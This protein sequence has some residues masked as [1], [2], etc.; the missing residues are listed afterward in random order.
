MEWPIFNLGD[1]CQFQNGF[2]FK[3]KYF[4]ISGTP[5]LRISNIQGGSIDL[6]R[7]AYTNPELYKENL[8]KY[9]VM[10]GD[11]LIAMSGATTGK[12]GINQTGLKFLLNQRVG[13]FIPSHKLDK[14]F[15][16]Y[17][18]S[19]KVE[20]LLGISAGAAQ[21]NLSTE[22]IKEMKVPLPSIPEQK[23]IVSVLDTVFSDLEQARAKTEQNLKNARELFDSY[24]QQVFSQKGEGWVD[25]PLGRVCTFK[26]GF[27]FKSEFFVDESDLILLTPGNFYEDGGYRDRGGKQKYYKGE[28]PKE[29]LLSEGSLLV[30]MTEQAAGLLG[31]SALVP[32]GHNFLHNQR[33]GLVEITSEFKNKVSLKFLFHLFNTKHFRQKV[34]KT[35]TGLKVRHTSPKKMEV[36]SVPFLMN[37]NEQE[38]I[39]QKLFKAKERA[40]ELETIYQKKL[41]AIDELKKSILQK[42]FS[43]ELTNTVE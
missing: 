41:N 1:I 23:R 13:K 33:L 15:L 9:L 30:A 19:T 17:F 4:E 29:F 12:I 42:A 20:E 39:A 10:D 26:H 27:A 18:L 3:S 31:S 36:I 32:K 28:F 43:G 5:I 16:Y 2:A 35:A 25:L 22:Q 14:Q 38:A 8:D 24:L 37:L 21:P 7:I 6:K 34:Q 11:L 40:I